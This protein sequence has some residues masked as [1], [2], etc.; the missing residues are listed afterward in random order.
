MLT[1]WAKKLCS[2]LVLLPTLGYS[3]P[4][5]CVLF[6]SVIYSHYYAWWCYFNAFNDDFYSQARHFLKD[7]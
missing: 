6:L 3:R 2:L 1:R 5:M 4:Y 7:R